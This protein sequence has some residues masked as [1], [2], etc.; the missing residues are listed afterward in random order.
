[1]KSDYPPAHSRTVVYAVKSV[2][3]RCQGVLDISGRLMSINPYKFICA[4]DHFRQDAESMCKPFK[5]VSDHAA[6]L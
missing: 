5:C 4:V 1:M 3:N 6:P 2:Q